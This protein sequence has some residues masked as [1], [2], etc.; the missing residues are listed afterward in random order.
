M[1]ATPTKH[2]QSGGDAAP[3]RPGVQFSWG[4]F[5]TRPIFGGC[6]TVLF[7]IA[8]AMTATAL[9][10][11]V[12]HD[13]T[14]S[15]RDEEQSYLRFV[16]TGRQEGRLQASIVRLKDGNGRIVDLVSAV[17]IADA[18]YYAELKRRFTKYDAVLYEMV[19][20]EG[21][22]PTARGGSR[23]GITM[24]QQSLQSV[25]ELDYQL[26]G[27][28]YGA[29]NFVHADLDSDRFA[30]LQKKRGESFFTLILK[31]MKS[32]LGK[33]GAGASEA[34]SLRLLIA[35]AS[36]D[37]ARALKFVLAEKLAKMQRTLRSF[38]EPLLG[39]AERVKGSNEGSVIIAE[40][41]KAAIRILKGALKKK[42]RNLAIFYGAAHMRDMEQRIC[43]EFGFQRQSQEWLTAWDVRARKDRPSKKN[44]S[45]NLFRSLFGGGASKRAES[46]D[47]TEAKSRDSATKE[48]ERTYASESTEKRTSKSDSSR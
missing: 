30:R 15:A 29:K 46:S 27:I 44:R 40:R 10:Q 42:K 16:R 39:N 2:L 14:E 18:T 8:L 25:L 31:G 17:H 4:D 41:N 7:A 43:T 24:L 13:A 6:V 38:E 22:D 28:D 47:A 12:P 5:L 3:A 23:S 33:R 37:S 1:A 36:D 26:D 32:D 35:L 11:D 48:Q 9:A 34:D 20:P 19:K 45:R 21:A